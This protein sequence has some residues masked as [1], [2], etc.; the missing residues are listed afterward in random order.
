LGARASGVGMP[1]VAVP[2]SLK[3]LLVSHLPEAL[4]IGCPET[5]TGAIALLPFSITDLNDFDTIACGPGLTLDAKSAIDKVL[6]AQCPL[7]LDA[8]GLNILAELETMSTLTTRR[9]KTILTPHLGEFRRL[10]PNLED[11]HDRLTAVRTAAKESGAIVLLKGAKTAIAAPDGSIWSIAESTPALA[12]GGS[13]DVLTGLMGGLVAQTKSDRS[14][15]NTVATAAWWHARAGILAA[16]ERTELGVD[17][18]SLSQY[19]ISVISF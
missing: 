2:E 17:A 5:K 6:Q 4:V 7:I 16:R 14:I 10:F 15:V 1:Y 13:G 18:V 8:D 9:S 3:S 12:R 19:L 11:I